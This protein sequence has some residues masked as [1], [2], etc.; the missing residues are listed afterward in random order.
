MC[1]LAFE[2]NYFGI[3]QE[4]NH[5]ILRALHGFCVHWHLKKI[6]TVNYFRGYHENIRAVEGVRIHCQVYIANSS[7][8]KSRESQ[9]PRRSLRVSTLTLI[10]LS[11]QNQEGTWQSMSPHK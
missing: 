10:T 1:A 2:E 4:E 7:R 8:R 11:E 5:E 9:D 6:P 3:L